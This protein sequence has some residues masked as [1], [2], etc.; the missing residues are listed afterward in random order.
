ME[1]LKV[2]QIYPKVDTKSSQSSVYFKVM[3]FSNAQIVTKYLGYF[4]KI[5]F[6]KNFQNSPNLATLF[7]NKSCSLNFFMIQKIDD[8][9]SFC[10]S[11][12]TKTAQA[13]K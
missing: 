12:T 2:A 13:K 10:L 9:F 4:C 5:F 11:K 8:Y 6:T 3:S 7:A 1:K